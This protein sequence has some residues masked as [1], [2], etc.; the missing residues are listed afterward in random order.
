[1]G[2]AQQGLAELER[3]LSLDPLS[4]IIAT[5]MAETYYLLRKPE[6]AMTQVNDVLALNP[7]FAQAHLVKGKILERLHQY[8]QAEEE[9]MA[10]SQLFGGGSNL[11]AERAHALALAG[12]P[13]QALQIVQDLERAS[14]QHYVSGVRLAQ[15]YCALQ[16]TNSAMTWLDR[17]YKRHDAGMN[18]LGVDPLFDGCRADAHFQ[19]LLRVIKL[20][21]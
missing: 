10:S 6:E 20:T 18:M 21:G 15:I 9:F 3:A 11:D 19:K 14:E 7:E 1:M 17:A 13:R 8:H 16:Q 5:D 4:L 2:K 12:E